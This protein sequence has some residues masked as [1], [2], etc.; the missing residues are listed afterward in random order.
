MSTNSHARHLGLFQGKRSLAGDAIRMVQR[1][2]SGSAAAGRHGDIA[3]AA[4][5]LGCIGQLGGDGMATPQR[6]LA[7]GP[8]PLNSLIWLSSSLLGGSM[9]THQ[10]RRSLV[11]SCSFFLS[12]A[13][14]S[15]IFQIR[16]VLTTDCSIVFNFNHH[17]L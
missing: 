9:A 7:G 8:S 10:L 11:C 2:A 12:V 16:A 5:G 3:A 14:I 15:T 6:Q 1:R 17:L 4:E 13:L